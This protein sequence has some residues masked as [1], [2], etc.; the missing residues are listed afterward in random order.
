MAGNIFSTQ[1]VPFSDKILNGGLN[2]TGGA[3]ELQ[4]NESSDLQN[5]DFDKF[6]SVLKRNG[7]TVLC[8][9]GTTG[10]TETDALH[11]YEYNNAGT[12]TRHLL[13]V[14]GSKL[15]K[16]DDL[17]GTW[18]DITGGVSITSGSHCD[19]ENA[20]NTVY[21]TNGVDAPFKW[22][23]TSTASIMAVPT[24]LTTA[25]Q[26]CLFNNYLFLG[27]VTVSSTTYPTRIY[28][29]HIRDANT[30]DSDQWIEV[31]MNDGQPITALMVL[32]DRLVVYKT[33][34]I[35]NVFFTGD[36]DFPFIM[37]GGGKSNSP[38]GCIAPFSVQEVENGHVFLAADGLYYYDG[39][40]AYKLSHK[41]FKTLDQDMNKTK[42][43][44]AVSCV[45]KDKNR[46]MLS[47]PSSGQ[48]NKNRVIVW[49]WFN[50]AFSLYTGM[51]PAAMAEVF[52]DGFQERICFSDYLGY[53][54]RMDT[55]TDD[56][57]SDTQTA[58]DAYYY[59][60]WKTFDDLCDQKGIPHVYIYYQSSSS[61]LTF[62]YSYDFQITDQYTQTVSL[63]T[64]TAVYG[65]A[66]YGTDV[67]SGAGGAVMRRDL[68]GR[69]RTVRFKFA[70]STIGET[71]Q[72]DGFGSYTHAETNV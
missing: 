11:W 57:P 69:G 24:G 14:T 32:Q 46:Y 44:E 68:T 28:W 21:M 52:V 6:G 2:S 26:V 4:N 61:I 8:S 58:I 16:M 56:Y 36:A 39:L 65:T 66:I 3:L 64:G 72:I 9:G 13:N 27:N 15:Y 29:S 71:F 70:N 59:T 62:A 33:R 67:Y 34:S 63:S 19:C 17:D 38:V 35:Y 12:P 18:D 48:T 50:N 1:S 23:G 42:F 7:Y 41:I 53:T 45:Y 5:I 47:I 22:A 40:N 51:Y 37:P 54:Y 10:V 20:F 31:G 25:K 43:D 55:G 30:W 49:D 60:N